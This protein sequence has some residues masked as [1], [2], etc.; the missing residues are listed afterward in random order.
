[1]IPLCSYKFCQTKDFIMTSQR[2]ISVSPLS[3]SPGQP[4]INQSAQRIITLL[5]QGKAKTALSRS[6]FFTQALLVWDAMLR[7]A[8]MDEFLNVACVGVEKAMSEIALAFEE[9][10]AQAVKNYYDILGATFMLAHLAWKDVGDEYT[11]WDLVQ[12]VVRLTLIDFRPPQPGDPPIT[13]HDPCCG[14]GAFLL[15]VLDYVDTYS[16]EV[17]DRGQVK[18]YGQEL[19]YV[20]WMMCRINLHLHQLARCFRRPWSCQQRENEQTQAPEDSPCHISLQQEG[21]WT[22]DIAI[23][24]DLRTKLL[25]S[26]RPTK[27]H[28]TSR[29]SK[30]QPPDG[31]GSLFALVDTLFPQD[32]DE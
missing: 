21:L 5:E 24:Q 27:H 22:P 30:A 29:R 4:L 32:S 18:V 13:V 25:T 15:G 23:D 2:S 14:S 12:L 28:R 19:T 3:S 10:F 11:P 9:L 6:N 31:L 17:L 26:Y 16:P 1:M 20:G 8:D 7:Q